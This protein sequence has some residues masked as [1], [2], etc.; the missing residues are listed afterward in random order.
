MLVAES[1]LSLSAAAAAELQ[2]SA[3]VPF[4]GL[5]ETPDMMEDEW[6][7]CSVPEAMLGDLRP[8]Y[9]TPGT[10]D[11]KL[12]L[13][14]AALCRMRLWAVLPQVARQAVEMVERYADGQATRQELQASHE[15][16]LAL[17]A[18]RAAS[19]HPRPE[20]DE[21]DLLDKMDAARSH[22][23][24]A[25][26]SATSL[27]DPET[28]DPVGQAGG[29]AHFTALAVGAFA[30]LG[31]PH[32]GTAWT[33]AVDFHLP[34]ERAWCCHLLRD[35]F[36]NP[37]RQPKVDPAWLKWNK[38]KVKKL[39]QDIYDNCSFAWD[40]MNRLADALQKAG[41]RNEEILNHCRLTYSTTGSAGPSRDRGT[42][43]VRGCWVLDMLLG[44]G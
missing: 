30:A 9:F 29:A 25:V 15:G 35:V 6:L 14:S 39:A 8:L 27:P 34:V 18:E 19:V 33:L 38:G 2:R 36:G 10:N 1:S 37:F 4:A 16:I 3:T 20:T 26:R 42:F 17:M 21:Q 5:G 28:E 24:E 12:R 43:H 32:V 40:P 22:A 23:L 7:S 31:A 13:V 44:K 41:C 11:R